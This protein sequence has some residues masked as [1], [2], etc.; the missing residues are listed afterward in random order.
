MRSIRLVRLVL[1]TVMAG[2]DGCKN[3]WHEHPDR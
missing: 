3:F 2:S 1:L